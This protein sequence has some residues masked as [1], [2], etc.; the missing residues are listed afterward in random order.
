MTLGIN[1]AFPGADYA[2][3]V[4]PLPP[5][6]RFIS[7]DKQILS[8]DLKT[9]IFQAKLCSSTT[10]FE[11]KKN[12]KYYFFFFNIPLHHSIQDCTR[13]VHFTITYSF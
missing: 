2:S 4:P 1:V 10:F 12:N 8:V 9:S 6:P 13:M 3:S 7:G 5:P 11:Q